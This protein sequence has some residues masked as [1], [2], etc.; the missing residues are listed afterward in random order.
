MA[1]WN[2]TR[3]D[4]KAE[5]KTGIQRC[6]IVG[7]EEGISKSSGNPMIIITVTP[8]GST[9]KVKNYI[10]KNDRFN[11]NMTQFFDAFPSIAEGNF[12]FI[13]WVGAEGAADFGTDENGY[14]KVKWFVNPGRAEHLPPFEGKKPEQ[15]T[16]ETFTEV[17]DDEMPF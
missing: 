4:T 9:A 17:S 6:V 1:D 10:V 5:V 16:V 7:A 15:Q 3:D 12:N 13:E 11:K 2:Y 8:S 14:L